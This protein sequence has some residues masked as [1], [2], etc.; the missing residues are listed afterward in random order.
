MKIFADNILI[1]KFIYYKLIISTE[2]LSMEDKYMKE[3]KTLLN[4]GLGTIYHETEKAVLVHVY[5]EYGNYRKVWLPKS[6][7]KIQNPH[8]TGW[9]VLDDDKTPAQLIQI[10]KWLAKKKGINTGLIVI[11]QKDMT[12]L[13]RSYNYVRTS[14]PEEEKRQKKTRP[15][16]GKR[17][18]NNGYKKK[19]TPK[20]KASSKAKTYRL[21]A[22]LVA[23]DPNEPLSFY[24]R[25]KFPFWLLTD[26]N[27]GV[28]DREKGRLVGLKPAQIKSIH[29][30]GK[31]TYVVEYLSSS[32]FYAQFVQSE[33]KGEE[34]TKLKVEGLDIDE[35]TDE[36]ILT[37]TEEG[38]NLDH[39]SYI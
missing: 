32:D 18:L 34:V 3:M 27:G 23:L 29:K 11:P 12:T 9:K 20:T 14:K 31:N 25:G 28:W 5:D 21:I 39:K 1:E 17:T 13:I 8:Q 2:V 37:K 36:I 4:E 30:I 22:K 6:Q 35:L 38:W 7:I 33:E 19:S 26:P 15:K 24:E 16:R 10:P